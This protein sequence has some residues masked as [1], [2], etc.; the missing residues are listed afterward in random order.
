MFYSVLT[1]TFL[2]IPHINAVTT[3]HFVNTCKARVGS[4]VGKECAHL[5]SLKI[6]KGPNSTIEPAHG[7]GSFG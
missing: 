2:M 7:A 1:L 5:L 6:G 4:R 3:I